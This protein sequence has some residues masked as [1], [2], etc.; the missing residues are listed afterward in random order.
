MNASEWNVSLFQYMF[1]T[2]AERFYGLFFLI[3]EALLFRV[4][5]ATQ[6]WISREWYFII[7]SFRGG[8]YASE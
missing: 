7:L 3:K 4:K 2:E 1:H 8:S 6:S 5:N